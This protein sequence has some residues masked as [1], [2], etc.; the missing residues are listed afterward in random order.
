MRM[1]P[2]CAG[3]AAGLRAGVQS[4]AHFSARRRASETGREMVAERRNK[5]QRRTVWGSGSRGGSREIPR[6][7]VRCVRARQEARKRLQPQLLAKEDGKLENKF[8]F[9]PFRSSRKSF[10]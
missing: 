3:G 7:G 8:A 4:G 10:C 6:G 9:F 2:V 5:G 1:Q